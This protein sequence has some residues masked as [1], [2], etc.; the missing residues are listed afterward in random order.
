MCI[1]FTVNS[2]TAGDDCENCLISWLVAC[3]HTTAELRYASHF[4]NRQTKIAELSSELVSSSN[5]LLKTVVVARLFSQYISRFFRNPK[6]A[7][8][9]KILSLEPTH[10]QIKPVHTYALVIQ[11]LSYST[12]VLC[13]FLISTRGI[14]GWFVV[15]VLA[16]F[17][18][19]FCV[20]ECRKNGTSDTRQ[21]FV[22]FLWLFHDSPYRNRVSVGR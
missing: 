10:S 8:V 4:G 16:D 3:C 14:T 7:Y 19:A 1:R 15:C 13:A 11:V 17:L 22:M 2:L 6:V 12:N 9:Y 20:I 18:E 21:S 5:V